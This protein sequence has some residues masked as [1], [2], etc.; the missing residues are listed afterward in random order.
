MRKYLGINALSSFRTNRILKLLQE[1]QLDIKS[2]SA[3]Y[4]HFVDLKNDNISDKEESELKKLLTYEAPCISSREGQKILV[5]PRSGTISPWSS[6]ATN[7]AKNSGLKSVSRIERGVIYYLK[8]SQDIDLE[9]IKY[10]F[11]DRMTEMVLGDTEDA[12]ILFKS[13]KPKRATEI[14]ILK[15][16]IEALEKANLA[17]GLALNDEEISYLFGEYKKI[18]RNPTDA[19]LVM[20]GQINSEHCRHKI[21]NAEWVIDG[22]KQPKSLFKMIKN[23]H[24]KN[25]D[26]VISAY[27]DNA[28][29]LNGPVVEK[30][31]PES[32][33]NEYKIHKNNA[34]LVIKAETHNHPTAIA[35]GPG[36]AT[37]V[38]GE[39]RDE[40][41]TGRGAKSKMG[42]TGY[43][44][45]NLEI[46]Q[47]KQPW[48]KHYGKPARISSALDIMVKAPVGGASFSNEFGRPNLGGYFRTFEQSYN[49]D[50][51]GYHKPLMIAGGLGNID[52]K[53]VK[54]TPLKAGDL[55]I[56]LGGPS[57]LIGLGGGAS[58][59]MQSG[60]SEEDLDFASV[61]RANAEM[62]RRTQEVISRCSSMSEGSPV[63]SIHDV[64]AGGLSNAI[65]EIA[66]D[67]SLGAKINLRDIPSSEAGLSPM[68]IWCN[69]AQERFVLAIDE[70]DLDTFS[71][72]CERERCPYAVVGKVTGKRDLVVYDDHFKNNP[73]NIPMPVLF[74]SP[75]KIVKTVFRDKKAKTRNKITSKI[76]LDEA[77]QRVLHIP[78]VGSK[79]FLITIGDRTVGGM[80]V[81]DPMVGP[82]QVPVS[83]AAVTA[84]SFRANSGEALSIG[85]RTP[86]ALLNATASARIAIGEAITNI[87]S[88]GVSRLSDIKLSANWMAASGY[89]NEDE[90][91]FDTVR[92]VGEELCPKL[93]LS[94]PVGKDSLSMRTAWRDSGKNKSVVSPVS[95]IISA[96]A[97]VD[98]TNAALTPMLHAKQQ[99]TL[100][101]VDLANGKK[102]LG[103]SALTQSYGETGDICPDLEDP[104]LL[105][106][107][108]DGIQKLNRLNLIN[109]YHDRSDGGLITTLLEMAFSGRC[110][111]SIDLSE[112]KGDYSIETLFNEELGAV[113]EVDN[114][115]LSK[116]S[117]VLEKAGQSFYKIGKPANNQKIQITQ[118]GKQIYS[119]TRKQLES[120]WSATSYQIQKIRDN[121]KLAN[122]EFNLINDDEDP[123][124][125]PKILFD[126][127]KLKVYKNR[128]KIAIL[129]EQGI[130]G[131]VEMAAAFWE[132]GFNPVDVHMSDLITKK[133]R[134]NDFSGMVTCGGFSYGDVLGGGGGWAKSILFNKELKTD[135]MTFFER[136]NTF[137][138]GVCNGCQMFSQLK[139]IIP[140][141]ELWPKFLKNESE[142]F[143][144]RLV[145]V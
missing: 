72:I 102:R 73:I 83:D 93:G 12:S 110:G 139:E 130:N 58:S 127:N 59:S 118:N 77:I 124:I 109:A 68:E 61:Q 9:K 71:K 137:S 47:F 143:E 22:E 11:Y 2:L 91:L 126:T 30:F 14:D 34:N 35:P 115:K 144:A 114:N 60:Q 55:L 48:E 26:G 120:W 10:L 13:D 113:I 122:E 38:G 82:W 41:A 138:L 78:S 54:K 132:A 134:I 94:V 141:A 85:E 21:F 89:K 108:F 62:Q 87:A 50:V 45:S 96:F 105:K 100:I 31:H 51:W 43:S 28:A 116:V 37:G 53:Q 23:T 106:N 63:K 24:E 56:V 133:T 129:R 65:P 86:I 119:N 95:L 76:N 8:S 111:L 75:P 74:G 44:V 117:E 69:E 140:G 40:A 49:D 92:T 4:V 98:D 97:P 15:K 123:G 84:N 1:E 18:N 66:Q 81:R 42:F 107:F 90:K 7:I 16:G 27:S 5:V 46:P 64:G 103:G 128:P 104:A 29:I 6:K 67:N 135:F 33:S 136:E 99:T 79:K 101:F 17:F 25:S 142:Q 52:G 145:S 36:A 39:I 88:A 3:E 121:E 57:M 125:S 32:S 80:S 19:E 20:F 112:L 70:S 131:Q